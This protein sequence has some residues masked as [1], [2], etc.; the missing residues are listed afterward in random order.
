MSHELEVDVAGKASMMYNSR[1]G[2]PW[3][4]LGTPVDG[5]ATAAEAIVAAG[6]DWE[7]EL[8]QSGF[9]TASG[10]WRVAP[11]RFHIVRVTDEKPLGSVSK[12]YV[13]VQNL[14]AFNFVD[15]LI[16]SDE[17]KY[18]TAGVLKE[19][20]RIFLS[21]KLPDDVEIAGD[22]YKGHLLF[23]SSHDGLSAVTARFVMT[24]V[25]CANT[26]G[27]AFGEAVPVWSFPHVK[28]I[29]EQLQ[30]AR[31]TLGLVTAYQKAF[32]DQ[33]EAMLAIDFELREMESVLRDV[34]PERLAKDE[35]VEAIVSN[36]TGS[37]T[38]ADDARKTAF[39][40]V[41]GFTEWAEH[42]RPVRS[43]EGRFL[44]VTEGEGSRVRDRLVKQV[45]ARA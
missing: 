19:G 24:R 16:D 15:A 36:V 42:L 26:L 9:K 39:G 5:L 21:A 23:S 22:K 18:D 28:G 33:V 25:V 34:L 2:V 40:L 8:R 4:G 6:M 7:V 35:N 12:R 29:D 17:A 30:Q 41:N 32:A 31:E 44:M 20:K 43:S 3:H 10:N 11:G 27:W 13:P 1:N 45:L 14:E 37:P 38:I